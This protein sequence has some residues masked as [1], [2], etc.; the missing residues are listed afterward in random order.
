M[1]TRRTLLIVALSLLIAISAPVAAL[2]WLCYTETGLLW[3]TARVTKVGAARIQVDGA[4]GRL[5]GPLSVARL[6]IDH[7]RARVIANEVRTD[8]NVRRIVLQTV[9][10]EYLDIGSVEVT[11]KPRARPPRKR[12]L[13]FAPRWL[14]L[15]APSVAIASARLTLLNG[16]ILS[17]TDIRAA[18][19]VT[20]DTLTVERAKLVSEEIELEG[21]GAL[22]ARVPLQLSGEINWRVRPARQP[23]WAGRLDLNGDLDRLEASGRV[24]EPI[25]AD[26]AGVLSDLTGEWRWEANT[27][28]SD[29]TLKPWSSGSRVSVRTVLLS[30]SG[31]REGVALNG[32]LHPV[33][34]ETGPLDVSF[35]GSYAERTLRADELRITQKSGRATLDASGSVRF[36]GADPTIDV[37]ATWRD[38]AWPLS[39]AAAMQSPEGEITLA[40]PLPYRYDASAELRLP[41]SPPMRLTGAGELDREQIRVARLIAQ[42]PRGDVEAEGVWRWADEDAWRVNAQARGLDPASIDAR[43]PGRLTFHLA[44]DGVGYGREATWTA[45]LREL[46]GE[47]RS[48][49]VRGRARVSHE[50]GSYRIGNANLRFGDA[51]LEA[52]GRYGR[53]HD[54]EW[55]LSV[56]DVAQLIPEARGSLRSRGTFAGTDRAPRIVASLSAQALAYDAYRVGRLEAEA[57]VDLA[58][59]HASR[60][61]VSGAKLELRGRAIS[62]AELV[63][64]GR[65]SAHQLSILVDA[66]NASLALRTASGYDQG[67]WRGRIVELDAG[68]GASALKLTEAAGYALGKEQIELEPLCLAGS[69]E[70]V[71]ARGDW[72]RSGPWNLGIDA[73]GVPLR[74]LAAGSRRDTEY[75]GVLTLQASAQ[76]EPGQPW[77]GKANGTFAEGLFRYRRANGEMENVRIGSGSASFEATPQRFSGEIRLDATEAASLH[78]QARADRT[79]AADWRRLPLAGS[80]R[81]ETRELGFVPLLASEIDRAS[82]NLRADLEL[83]GTLGAPEIAGALILQQGE[84]DLYAVNLQLRDL[85]MRVD[86]AGT[87]LRLAA[88]ASAGKGVA[89]LDGELEWRNRQPIGQIRLK[90]ENLDLVNVPEA[91]V[92]VSPNLRFRID[93]RRIGVDGAVRVPSAFLTPADLSGAVL[94]SSDEVIVGPEARPDEPG[95]EVTTGIQLV[96]GKDVRVDSYG[97]EARIEGNIAAYAA[98]N[99]VSTAT[100]ELKV[101]E[102]KYSAYTRELDIERGR[103]IFTGGPLTD[104]GVDLRA[105]KQ[106]PEALVGVNVRGT[107]RNPRL[108]FWSEPS[109]PQSQIASLIVT[110]GHLD[111]FQNRNGAGNQNGRDS[112]LAQGS[113]ILASQLGEQLGLD[114]EEVRLESDVNDQTRLVLGRYL[115]PRFYVSYGISL[116]EAINTLKLRYTINDRWTVRSE[117]GEHRSAD[118]EYKIER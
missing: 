86:L 115:S 68:F 79:V 91:R 87:G 109:L 13:R 48:H 22:R 74:V 8:V 84:L 82:G 93:G 41:K 60:L 58:D 95:F 112:L 118:L 92:Q 30:G 97:L 83:S 20:A 64:D 101:A 65:A 21:A 88:R 3:L 59:E 61:Q 49:P 50:D 6:E 69:S 103:L 105:R 18:S 111:A 44:A 56:P 100:G 73:S 62:S 80:L 24:A 113:A 42:T 27:S 29:F 75:S 11:I 16:R 106:F 66:D 43:F 14:R 71:C 104:P 72:R 57:D 90:G 94:A 81:A 110:G 45:E 63:L 47:L 34:P 38:L 89:E 40:G 35:R 39:S 17:A 2:Y 5:A 32:S 33:V 12:V 78:A 76:Q 51:H 53:A 70:R 117:A 25:V 9:H 77:I 7:E 19:S 55:Q 23:Q 116:T 10:A 1:S 85:G 114:L 107:L 28:A 102:G 4:R 31:N 54:L 26:L 52:R 46:R 98:P 15:Q 36:A 96:L 37:R 67:V 99:E 108:S